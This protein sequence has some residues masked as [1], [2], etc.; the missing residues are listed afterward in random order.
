[1]LHLVPASANRVV[2]L[3]QPGKYKRDLAVSMILTVQTAAN[4]IH[5]QQY[6]KSIPFVASSL[7]KA[8]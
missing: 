2:Q 4:E 6:P 1:M 7:P 3:L 8:R 5:L